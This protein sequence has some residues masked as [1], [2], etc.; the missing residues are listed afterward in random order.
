VTIFIDTSA[1]YAAL[2]VRDQRHDAARE[3]WTE[4]LLGDEQLITSN[5]VLV[6]TTA[7]LARRVGFEAVRAFQLE[8]APAINITWV[9]EDLHQRAV[10]AL[11]TAGMRDLSLVDCVSFEVMRTFE[12]GTAFAFDAHFT[13][14]GFTAIP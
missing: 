6:E 9:D 4:L 5:Y 7:L 11:L 3:R 13:E 2:T 12:V 10:T 8:L 14:Q 1:L